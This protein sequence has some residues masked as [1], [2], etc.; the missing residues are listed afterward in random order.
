MLIYIISILH[1]FDDNNRKCVTVLQNKPLS[2][3]YLLDNIHS[4]NDVE[5]NDCYSLH[6]LGVHLDQLDNDEA[7]NDD[8]P[9]GEIEEHA[10]TAFPPEN[11]NPRSVDDDDSS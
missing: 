6:M 2:L 8:V 5:Q 11:H 4:E 9:A 1:E 7:H 10:R 3:K